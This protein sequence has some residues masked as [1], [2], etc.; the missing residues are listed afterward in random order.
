MSE[1]ASQ[2]IAI[3]MVSSELPEI[4]GMSDRVIVMSEG[5]ITAEFSKQ[6]ANSRKNYGRY[7]SHRRKESGMTDPT[8]KRKGGN[9]IQ[10]ISNQRE[11]TI[12]IVIILV[13][14]VVSL[15]TPYFLTKENFNDIFINI[16]ILSIVAIGQMMVI[17]TSGI[18]LSVASVIGFSAMTVGLI[19]RDY[20]TIHPL[21]TLPMGIL[22]GMTLGAINGLLITKGRVPAIITTLSTMGIYRGAILIISKGKWVNTYELPADFVQMT[23]ATFLGIPNLVWFAAIVAILAY[24][25]VGHTRP[26]RAIYT[27]GGNLVGAKMA[28]IRTEK[29]LLSVYTI[30]GSLAG[31]AGTLWVSRQAAAWNDTALGFELQTVAACVLGG[32]NIMGGTGTIPG[33]LLGALLLGVVNVSVRLVDISP[34]W[35]TAFYGAVILIAVVA[36]ALISRRIQRTLLLRRE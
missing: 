5:R 35:E 33:V 17:I 26:G 18:D 22:I 11:T 15:A 12:I 10:S 4:I 16:S 7:G 30:S 21:L 27:I 1:L 24:Y 29:V 2:G 13:S 6:D 9:L 8:A 3:L 14:I 28:G 23:R 25:F 31:L 19:I 34:F 20:P 32:V 36:D